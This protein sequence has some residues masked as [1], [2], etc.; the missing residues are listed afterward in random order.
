MTTIDG[1]D[2]KLIDSRL[3]DL[4]QRVSQR[5]LEAV[6]YAR[7]ATPR[8]DGKEDSLVYFED[9][10][11]FRRRTSPHSF[12]YDAVDLSPPSLAALDFACRYLDDLRGCTWV[13]VG[14]GFG[15]LVIYLRA[16]GYDA[17]GYDD[18]SQLRREWAE[19]F[20]AEFIQGDWI[21]DKPGGDWK[22]KTVCWIWTYAGEDFTSSWS[23][24]DYRF[25]THRG[26]QQLPEH[27]FQFHPLRVFYPHVFAFYGREAMLK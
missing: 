6:E 18:W 8:A 24:L 3:G 2:L 5:F 16:L 19:E 13:D 20:A 4:R 17:W 23:G 12:D 22:V 14:C 9:H 7:A 15:Q 10:A 1:P 11:N 27:D 25:L 26:E 21:L